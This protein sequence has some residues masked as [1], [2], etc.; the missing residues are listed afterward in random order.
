MTDTAKSKLDLWVTE[1][2]QGDLEMRYRVRRTLFSGVSAFQHIDIVETTGYGKVLF[3]DGVVMISERDEFVYHEMISH[4]PLF[5]HPGVTRVLVIGGGDGGTVR[6]LLRHPSVEHCRLVEIDSLVVEG[7]RKHIPQ[8]AAALDDARV[9]VSIA[10]GVEFVARTAERYDLVLVDSTDPIGP[11]TPLFGAEFYSN[12]H[13]VL[14]D[15]GIVVSQAE[16]PFYDPKRQ[17]SMVEILAARFE[18]VHIYNYD[19]LT[20]PGGLWSFTFAGK[21]DRCPI[22][23]FDAAR[24]VGC[25]LEFRYY[26]PEMHRAAFV[27]PAFQ[28]AA[29]RDRLS[30][31][32]RSPTGA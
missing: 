31:F 10:D 22:A 25:G 2:H 23:D 21:S 19:N 28:F 1:A 11:A 9:E 6:E 8:T 26:S 13:R 15:G 24:A 4:V 12:V 14:N 3:N 16:S 5:V 29:L 18:R 20:Y 17:R 27:L 30:P 32:K 7:C